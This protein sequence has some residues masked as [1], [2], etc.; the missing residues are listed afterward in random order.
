MHIGAHKNEWGSE[1]VNIVGSHPVQEWECCYLRL[2]YTL[3]DSLKRDWVEEVHKHQVGNR[4]KQTM[5]EK[6]QF[7]L[8]LFIS[9]KYS[10]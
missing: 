2:L 6:K 7:Y 4:K 10:M 9:S 5:N 3:I 8:L 1:A